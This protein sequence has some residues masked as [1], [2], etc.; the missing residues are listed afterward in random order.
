MN[1]MSEIILGVVG[2]LFYLFFTIVGLFW[3][4]V[5]SNHNFL[6]DMIYEVLPIQLIQRVPLTELITLI[7]AGGWVFVVAALISLLTGIVCVILIKKSDNVTTIGVLFIVTGFLS[8][9]I[10]LGILSIAGF[11]Y[12]VAGMICL[13]RKVKSNHQEP[14]IEKSETFI[15]V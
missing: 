6:E 2:V 5:F 15:D 1:R 13:T 14:I 4:W 10:T 7:G 8:T 3:L 12:V 11:I 9:S